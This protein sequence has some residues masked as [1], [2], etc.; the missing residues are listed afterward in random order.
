MKDRMSRT[1]YMTELALLIAVE[2]VMKL[3]GLG[4]VPVGPLYMSFLTVPIAVGAMLLGPTAG[5]VLGAVFGAVSFYD[6]MTGASAM[7]SVFL[8]ISPVKTFLLC[9]GMR[10]LMGISVGMIWQLVK[11]PLKKGGIRC[12]VT[13]LSAPLLNTLFF[14]GFIVLAFYNTEY[15]QN[16]AAKLGAVNPLMFVILLVGFQGLAEAV[17]C[18]AVGGIVG[19]ALIRY[20]KKD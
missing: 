9:V 1:R 7:T 10:M 16:I 8:Q 5:L 6:S 19:N 2:I 18:T 11:H 17:V 3:T 4:S 20:T 15:I 13:A 12:F 14:M